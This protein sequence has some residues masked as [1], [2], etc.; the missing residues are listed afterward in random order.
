MTEL[1]FDDRV[2]VITGA[3]RGLG[4][5]YAELLGTEVVNAGP[6]ALLVPLL[7]SGVVDE[8]RADAQFGPAG[9]TH[10]AIHVALTPLAY[11]LLAPASLLVAGAIAVGEFVVHYHIDWLKEQATRRNGLTPQ[12]S[13]FWHVLGT[14]QLLH[15]LTYVAIVAVLIWTAASI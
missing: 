10:A 12:D 7:D 9:L 11:L 6:L 4:R 2:A 13:C 14:D 8:T 15:G 1:R 5:A 3:G